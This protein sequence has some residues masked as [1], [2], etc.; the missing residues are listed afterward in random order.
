M[1]KPVH[2][3]LEILSWE[4]FYHATYSSNLAPSEYH[5]L[6]SLS[7]LFADERFGW[8]EDLKKWPDEWFAT[9]GEDLYRHGI[10]K[11]PERFEKCI[12]SDGAY[13]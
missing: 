11:L 8:Y 10:H 12:T 7:H 3:S 6:A 5:L 2:D 4:N 1:A 13:F 9:R